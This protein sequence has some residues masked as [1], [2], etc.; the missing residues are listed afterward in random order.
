MFFC[1]CFLR[2]CACFT[3]RAA[4]LFPHKTHSK[5]KRTLAA[6][7]AVAVE[8]QSCL[9]PKLT[10]KRT[11]AAYRAAELFPP[12][13]SQQKERWLRIERQSCFLQ[14]LTAKRT[15]AAYRAVERQ[16]CFLPKLTENQKNAG[17][18]VEYHA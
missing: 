17:Y 16:S 9:L 12:K 4:E 1:I 2:C 14:K 15:L 6:Y 8:R 5:L 11:L 18:H 3:R 13:N 7:R 10:A